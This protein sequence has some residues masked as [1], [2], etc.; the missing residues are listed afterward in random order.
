[1]G[2]WIKLVPALTTATLVAA[3]FAMTGQRPLYI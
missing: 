2:L 3:A 1:M